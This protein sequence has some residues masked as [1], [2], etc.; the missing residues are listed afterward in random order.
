MLVESTAGA[1]APRQE[2]TLDDV[3]ADLQRLRGDAGGP[4]YNEIATRVLEQRLARGLPEARARIARSTV[5]D[6]FRPGRRRLDADLVAEIVLAL[7]G[8]DPDRWRREVGAAL[9]PALTEPPAVLAPPEATAVH[10][11][12]HRPPV[13]VALLVGAVAVNVL[14]RL[15]VNTLDLQLHL[16]MVGTA[17]SAIALGPWWGALVGLVTNVSTVPVSGPES[18]AFAP[19]NVLGALVWGYGVRR[20]GMGRTF[21][22]FALLS[23]VTGAICSMLAVPIL[24]LVLGGFSGHAEQDIGATVTTA[25]GSLILGIVVSNLLTNLADKLISGF[26]ALALLEAAPRLVVVRGDAARRGLLISR[27]R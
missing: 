26:V 20:F 3:V 24:Y 19:V 16:D 2:R 9:R 4:S 10:S 21:P 8:Q 22:R 12:R 14:G 5:Y 6:V 23:L 7:G 11:E 1:P 18:L 27:S 17:F 15:L 25:T 13:F